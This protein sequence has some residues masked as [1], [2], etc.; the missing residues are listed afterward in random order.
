MLCVASREL[1][2]GLCLVQSEVERWRQR[3]QR[4]PNEVIRCDVLTVLSRKRPHLDGAALFS[5]LPARRHISLLE[6]LVRYEVILEFLDDLS[7]RFADIG[8][9]NA[10]QLHL[11]LVQA[12]DVASPIADYY[13]HMRAYDD[14]GF[15]RELVEA[16]RSSCAVLPGYDAVRPLLVREAQRAGV[17]VLNHESNPNRRD[18]LLRRWANEQFGESATHSWF[19][20]TGAAT[21]SLTVHMLLAQAAES[22][23]HSI[24]Q[25]YR[26]YFPDVALLS[27]MLDS[28]IDDGADAIAEQHSYIGHYEGDRQAVQRLRQLIHNS[29]ASVHGLPRGRRHNVLVAAMIALYLSDDNARIERRRSYTG[30]LAGAGGLLT[31]LLIPI[32]R[33]WRI[34]YRLRS[35]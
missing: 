25:A 22:D 26:A 10:R 27:T 2:W 29:F 19:E 4:I 5:A 12:V 9:D 30:Q 6:A 7:E 23:R 3:A 33:L 28:Y 1:S 34:M 14:G 16:C 15:L 18:H 8:L 17:L 24:G 31:R 13:R 20:L 11:A 35:A 21:S 32:L